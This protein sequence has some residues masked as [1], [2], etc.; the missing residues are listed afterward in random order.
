MHDS[1]FTYKGYHSSQ[2]VQ[3]KHGLQ[4]TAST[5]T[6]LIEVL[7]AIRTVL[8]QAEISRYGQR[9]QVRLLGQ[10]T[11]AHAKAEVWLY[12]FRN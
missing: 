7:F 11:G 6:T 3:A 9:W 2:S 10:W 8:V 5:E 4:G 12:N 1:V